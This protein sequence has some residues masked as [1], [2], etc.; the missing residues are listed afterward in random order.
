MKH[1]AFGY[2]VDERHFTTM[3]SM[4]CLHKSRCCLDEYSYK[5]ETAS[6]IYLA[7]L[8]YDIGRLQCA[9]NICSHVTT[10]F[11]KSDH[12]SGVRYLK[13]NSLLFV[14]D[15]AAIAGFLMLR[16]KILRI[17]NKGIFLLSPELFAYYLLFQCNSE[18]LKIR[19]RFSMTLSF[20]ADCCLAAILRYKILRRTGNTIHKT[21]LYSRFTEELEV[22]ATEIVLP[23]QT[24]VAEVFARISNDYMTSF[25][26]SVSEEFGTKFNLAS[27]YEALSLYLYR[28]YENVIGLCE[29]LLEEP[30]HDSEVE[31]FQFL[32]VNVSLHF[33]AYFDEDIQ[34]LVG[35]QLLV[36]RLSSMQHYH[37]LEDIL[38]DN[39]NQRAISA[40]NTFCETF[41]PILRK[42]F[43]GNYLKLR[44]L[45]DLGLPLFEVRAALQCLKSHLLFENTLVQFMR[46]KIIWLY[47]GTATM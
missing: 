19:E 39:R 9:G 24:D 2:S 13:V 38:Y 18:R 16:R 37:I 45:L 20:E 8:F 4:L 17:R 11:K 6:M 33:I 1:L 14:D 15:L 43:L 34:A 41:N 46:Q 5:T 12:C 26:A 30:E 10:N 23:G 25:Y 36:L 21:L 44:C 47:R 40:Y 28:R 32:N 42:Q 31:K 22:S 7:A 27:C 29:K 3:V 35:F